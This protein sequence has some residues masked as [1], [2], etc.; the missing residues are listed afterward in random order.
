MEYL[1]NIWLKEG[2]KGKTEEQKPEGQ[3]KNNKKVD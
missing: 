3:T 1:K 2:R